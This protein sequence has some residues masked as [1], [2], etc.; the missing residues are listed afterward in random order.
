M[1]DVIAEVARRKK[2]VENH[3]SLPLTQLIAFVNELGFRVLTLTQSCRP[4]SKKPGL[5]FTCCLGSDEG[6]VYTYCTSL[7]AQAAVCE[8]LDAAI[9]WNNTA[10][11]RMLASNGMGYK[12]LFDNGATEL[13]VGPEAMYGDKPEQ[14]QVQRPVIKDTPAPTIRERVRTPPKPAE[15][16]PEHEQ[17]QRPLSTEPAPVVRQRTRYIVPPVEVVSR[18]AS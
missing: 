17:V 8:A 11:P 15:P 4:G 16:T 14:E 18:P 13:Y 6:A 3:R 9:R 12:H 7:N 5:D 2:E 1:T 10:T